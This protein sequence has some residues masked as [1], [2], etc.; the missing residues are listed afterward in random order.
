[1]AT[2]IV[3]VTLSGKDAGGFVFQNVMHCTVDPGAD[4]EPTVLADVCDTYEIA[5]ETPYKNAIPDSFKL[6]DLAARFIDGAGGFTFHKPLNIIGMRVENASAGALAARATFYPA[7]GPHSGHMYIAGVV[8]G[9]VEDDLLTDAYIALVQDV[10][11]GVVGIVGAGAHA[12]QSCLYIKNGAT[13]LA[14]VFGYVDVA[15]RSLSKRL[16]A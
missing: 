3:Q 8:D 13:T 4:D 1:M 14:I 12:I 7:S 11:D 5:L 2:R 15:V 10:V 16:R 6:F 9:D